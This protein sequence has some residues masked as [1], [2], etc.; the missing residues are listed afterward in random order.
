MPKNL[1]NVKE[2]ILSVTK[3]LIK[4]TGYSEL[5]IRK[6]AATCGVA[7]GTVY[8]YYSSKIDIIAEI[9]LNEWNLMLRRIDLN[10][11][12][13]DP[14]IE[15]IE[16]MFNEMNFFMTNVHGAWFQ[17]YPISSESTMDISKIKEKRKFLR[18]QLSAKVYSFTGTGKPQND[19]VINICDIISNILISYANDGIEFSKLK[20][21]LSALIDKL[22]GLIRS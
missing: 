16:I 18:N 11:K 19:E 4:Q 17:T 12:T 5:S 1:I 7:T 6:I 22:D 15:K 20:L 13:I 9:L 14:V 3:E 8:N 2:D 10:T 21:S